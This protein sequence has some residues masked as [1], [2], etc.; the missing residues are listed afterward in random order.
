M[1]A[2]QPLLRRTVTRRRGACALVGAVL[3]LGSGLATA[4]ATTAAAT[5]APSAST[6]STRTSAPARAATTAPAVVGRSVATPAAPRD[7][8]R[9]IKPGRPVDIGPIVS[10]LFHRYELVNTASHLRADV[11]WG[12][13]D[14]L[15]GVFLWPDN[16]SR[17]QEFTKLDTKDGWFRLR[18]R[19]S[20]QCL[21]LDW[22]KGSY[23]NGTKVIQHGY[24]GDDYEPA[25]WQF[26][27]LT[28][29]SKPC[30]QG[31]PYYCGFRL[32]A[33]VLV[34]RRTGRCLDAENGALGTPPE[35]AVLQ[36]WDCSRYVDDPK[37]GNQGWG[38]NDLDAPPP[39]QPH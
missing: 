12:S 27:T 1:R 2:P 33:T 29:Y 17:S 15:T 16:D 35:R 7:L 11:M 8:I 28:D 6:L 26:R 38:L 4:P 34:N 39:V 19:H 32:T 9:P 24:C 31:P 13:T 10:R 36:Q 30:T 23:R 5:T 18:A 22:R 37:I 20:G 3:A 14:P 21:M 25:Q